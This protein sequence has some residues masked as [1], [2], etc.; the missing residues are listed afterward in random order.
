MLF[1]GARGLSHLESC[2]R[3]A[4]CYIWR[5]V[6]MPR[7]VW[8]VFIAGLLLAVVHWYWQQAAAVSGDSHARLIVPKVLLLSRGGESGEAS[9][10]LTPLASFS[11]AWTD[12]AREVS[13]L[14]HHFDAYNGD[15]DSFV[16]LDAAHAEVMKQADAGKVPKDSAVGR[17]WSGS[18]ASASVGQFP[19]DVSHRRFLSSSEAY[20]NWSSGSSPL[21]FDE[22]TFRT[23]AVH[24][25][26]GDEWNHAH[27]NREAE[28]QF[29][30]LMR[31]QQYGSSNLRCSQ[32]QYVILEQWSHGIFSRFHQ[33]IEQLIRVLHAGR[34]IVSAPLPLSMGGSGAE[35]LLQEGYTR[36]LLPISQCAD[37]EFVR[38]AIRDRESLAAIGQWQQ[39][40]S[41][42]QIYEA[43][44]KAAQFWWFPQHHP[45]SGPLLPRF[46]PVLPHQLHMFAFGPDVKHPQRYANETDVMAARWKPPPHGE[47]LQHV[48]PHPSGSLE[49]HELVFQ[50]FW[51]MLVLWHYHPLP[52]IQAS[53]ALL[54][55]HWAGLLVD[56]R[57]AGPDANLT[58]VR[59]Q[60]PAAHVHSAA[61][62]VRRGD[63][64]GEDP[65]AQAHG[66]FR[67]V[68]LYLWPVLKRG[69]KLGRQWSSLFFMSD[70]PQLLAETQ[71]CAKAARPQQLELEREQVP[72]SVGPVSRSS[73]CRS[74]LSEYALSGIPLTYNAYAPQSCLD[75]F[76]RLG[77]DQFFVSLHY[78][79]LH[80]DF[81][82]GHSSSNVA[83]AMAELLYATRQLRPDVRSLRDVY[84]DAVDDYAGTKE[85]PDYA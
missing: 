40:D 25:V 69:E 20:A 3:R 6:V 47:E 5:G 9:S 58:A 28:R 73:G 74:A 37:S 85:N 65:Y 66:A 56:A 17:W 59:A 51:H 8:A 39:W 31:E 12:D 33:A 52:R 44:M 15:K 67:D 27:W 4:P 42:T 7:V 26:W 13:Q 38:A 55:Q 14:R 60:Y 10:G 18:D 45:Y 29:Y 83:R 36:F 48:Y 23:M 11:D 62:M 68:S 82:V 46:M 75:S 35:D 24:V 49:S 1:S 16:S 2:S 43:Q 32:R 54:R 41:M 70:D 80:A 21:P 77:L 76:S 71:A 19:F 34:E 30:H 64:A 81:L 50:F 61:V 79:L 72:S 22:A 84:E 53:T 78:M 63:K 57:H